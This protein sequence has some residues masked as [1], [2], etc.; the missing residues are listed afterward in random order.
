MRTS[1]LFAAAAAVTG[2]ASSAFAQEAS[3]IA[4]LTTYFISLNLTS[5][6]SVI[7]QL[8]GT[9]AGQSIFTKLASGKP[10]TFLAPF[11]DVCDP[12]S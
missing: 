5:L 6:A 11:N 1:V 10:Y 8:N 7:T 4:G 2:L 12:A 3:Y 9:E